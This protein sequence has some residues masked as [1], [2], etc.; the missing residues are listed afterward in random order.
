MTTEKR[1][2][3][4]AE[5]YRYAHLWNR[6]RALTYL[7]RWRK[8]DTRARAPLRRCCQEALYWYSKWI[9]EVTERSG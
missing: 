9:E 6:D 4:L 3:S 1:L 8:G 2:E 5:R 7:V